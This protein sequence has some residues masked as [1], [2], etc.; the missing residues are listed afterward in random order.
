MAGTNLCFHQKHTG[1]PFCLCLHQQCIIF[2][3]FWCKSHSEKCAVKFGFNFHF[4]DDP[5][6]RSIYFVWFLLW[7]ICSGSLSM[8]S[9][10]MM[11]NYKSLQWRTISSNR[12]KVTQQSAGKSACC[13]GKGP[14]FNSQYPHSGSEPSTATVWEDVM[15]SALCG[16]QASMWCTYIYVRQNTHDHKI[17]QNLKVVINRFIKQWKKLSAQINPYFYG[18]LI[19][20]RLSPSF[21]KKKKEKRKTF[22]EKVTRSIKVEEI[23]IGRTNYIAIFTI[24][25]NQDKTD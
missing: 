13:S 5:D 4:S 20:L 25:R 24:C 14:R 7:N 23:L 16:H 10:S 18:H 19:L 8:P 9:H 1:I 15:T 6:Y 17:K 22:G 3:R 11:S 12:H 21:Q 2:C